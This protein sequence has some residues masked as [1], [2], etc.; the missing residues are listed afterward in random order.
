MK[1]LRYQAF[2]NADR[3]GAPERP[4]PIKVLRSRNP[5]LV[6]CFLQETF[7][8]ESYQP[9]ISNERLV[10]ALAGFLE[11]WGDPDDEVDLQ[12]TLLSYD[13]RAARRLKDWV[14]E[15]YLT[16]YTNDVGEDIHSLT[17][18]ME[19][20]LDW[21]ASLMQ[22]RSFVGTESRFLDI[23]QKLRELVQNTA[24]D[25]RVKVAELEQQKQ[26]IDE[27]IRQLTLSQ[28][29]QTFADYQVKE[30]FQEVN[31]V[32]RSLLR[33]FR[34]VEDHFQQIARAIYQK[35]SA[36]DQTKGGVLGFA[37]D[38]LDELRQT[39]EGRSFEAFYQHLT[40]PTQKAELDELIRRVFALLT[41]RG[42]MP[43]DTFIRKIKFYLHTEGQKVN[44]SFY[45]LAQK[46]ERIIAEE[47]IRERRKSLSLI[48]EIRQ[49]A[50]A[51]ID[52]P[53][54]DEAF[55]EIDGRADYLSTDTVVS[56]TERETKIAPRALSVADT[57]AVSFDALVSQSVVDRA[58]LLDQVRS[59]LRSQSQVTLRTVV[60][61][62]G[63]KHGLSE[64]MAYGSLAAASSKHLINDHHRD[65][66]LVGPDR[67]V[68][69]PEII[70]CR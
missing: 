5:A 67:K 18:E 38:A 29:V 28:T 43:E 8:G 3:T 58:V 37:L 22:K 14:R 13:E 56:L 59:L 68:Q 4:V 33:D 26:A 63:L 31:G 1:Y 66:Y 32:A 10:G 9:T 51:V 12:T 70:F 20:V 30:R 69:F 27:Q 50:F 64:L 25:W 40:D 54:R 55:L 60:D 35:Q 53:P 47:N 42:L 36:A 61:V 48:A 46:L 45:R 23:V 7:K 19:T 34:E 39:D 41:E 6:L 21:V 57:E 16:L 2:F 62:F 11:T 24:E 49:L 65:D 17:P 44:D 52:K 15:G